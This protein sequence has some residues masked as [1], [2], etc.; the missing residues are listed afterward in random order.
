MKKL[1]LRCAIVLFCSN[2]SAQTKTLDPGF[3]TNG[4]VTTSL[5]GN[6]LGLAIA[7]QTD[8]KILVA[9]G[10][11]KYGITVVRYNTDGSLDTN[12]GTN[13]VASAG[14]GLAQAIALQPDGKIVVAGITGSATAHFALVRFNPNGLLDSTFGINGK[15]ITDVTPGSDNRAYTIVLQPNGKIIVAGSSNTANNDDFTLVRYNSDGSIDS[16]FGNRGIVTTQFVGDDVVRSIALQ[17]DGK[18]VAAGSSKYR[19]IRPLVRY[20]TLSTRW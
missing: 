15:V 17:S 10:A 16:G 7:L 20:C 9:G 14:F 11:N 13:G 6:S 12:F 19:C 1:I 8:S 3:G 2:L 5:G 4:I 18:I